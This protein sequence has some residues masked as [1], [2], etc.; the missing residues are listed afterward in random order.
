M[1][2][3]VKPVISS[4][5]RARAFR[6][7]AEELIRLSRESRVAEVATELAVM[8]ASLHDRALRLEGGPATEL[9]PLKDRSDQHR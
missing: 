2:W 4:Q 1:V 7:Q 6:A 5:D 8:A 9:M 3:V